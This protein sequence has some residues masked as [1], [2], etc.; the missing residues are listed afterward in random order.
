[1][2]VT[3]EEFYEQFLAAVAESNEQ[4]RL[5]QEVK[6]RMAGV[7][8]TERSP[9]GAVQVTVDKDGAVL[10][11]RFFGTAERL[12]PRQLSVVAMNCVR[13]AQGGLGARFGQVVAASGADPATAERLVAGYR[14]RHPQRFAA[15]LTAA[16]PS[17]P[18]PVVG[19]P[20]VAPPR[21]RPEPD[22]DEFVVLHR[23]DGN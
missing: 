2:Q 22:E 4:A 14:S 18:P 21:A 20:R 1:V 17:P 6:E 11:I 7:C 3:P 10:D 23:V 15:A 5:A 13:A 12:Q 8:V 16:A 9:D 19:P